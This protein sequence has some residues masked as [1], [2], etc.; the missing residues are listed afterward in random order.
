[1]V[2][3]GCRCESMSQYFEIHP[4]NPQPRLLQQAAQIVSA[5]GVIALPTDSSYAL[6]CQPDNKDAIERIRRIRAIDDKHLLTLLC[7][8]LAEIAQYAKVDNG[9]YRLLRAATPGAY[10]FILEATKVVPRRLSHPSRKT[11]GLRVPENPIAHGLLEE[12]DEPLVATTLILPGE[13]EPL[14]EPDEIRER[15]GKLVDL[16]MDGGTCN[17][18]PTT[19]VDLTTSVPELVRA[20]RGD[21]ARLGL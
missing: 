7:R 18:G 2:P 5:G 6:A 20:G 16:V 14:T 19:I 1:M 9:Q 10:T 13:E 21:P 4:Q 11:I 17:Q 3:M 8:D 15:I 12:L